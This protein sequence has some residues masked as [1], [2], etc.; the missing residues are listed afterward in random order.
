MTSTTYPIRTEQTANGMAELGWGENIG[1]YV[2]LDGRLVGW[3]FSSNEIAEY[4][5]GR[6]L[7]K[8]EPPTT[9]TPPSDMQRE[10]QYL[11]DDARDMLIDSMVRCDEGHLIPRDALHC[12]TCRD[13][14]LG[15][16]H[17]LNAVQHAALG[18]ALDAPQADKERAA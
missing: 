9:P 5:F 14:Y 8:P 15:W 6:L 10:L 4:Q 13:L 1:L 12:E 16:A 7:D 17:G 11:E 3:S 2:K 18:R